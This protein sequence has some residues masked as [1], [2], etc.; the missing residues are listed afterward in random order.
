MRRFN[1][2]L[3]EETALAL[4]RLAKERFGGNRSEAV[5]AAVLALAGRT[6]EGWVLT[7][8]TPTEATRE[9][10][11]HCCERPFAPGETAYRPVFEK[12]PGPGALTRLPAGP[13]LDCAACAGVHL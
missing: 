4:D 12:R 11:C 8:F 13:W 7:G 5:R 9:A 10:R 2:T 3:D 6:Q 1:F